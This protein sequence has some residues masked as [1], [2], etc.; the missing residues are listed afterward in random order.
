MRRLT[1]LCAAALLAAAAPAD[2]ALVLTIAAV[3][4]ARLLLRLAS[5]ADWA[6][7]PLFSGAAYALALGKVLVAAGGAREIARYIDSHELR[8]FTRR[9]ITDP[10]ALDAHLCE[11]RA[12]GY[13][14]EFEEF[15]RN[16]CCVAVPVHAPQG[17]VPGAVALSTTVGCSTAELKGLVRIARAGAERIETALAASSARG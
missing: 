9:T 16:L 1:C 4:A 2:A 17:R 7:A 5:P 14:T 12:R 8:P 13:A 15:A 3:V 11:V 6:R 10:V